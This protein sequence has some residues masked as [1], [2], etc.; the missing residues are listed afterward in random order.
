MDLFDQLQPKPS[1]MEVKHPGTGEGTGLFLDL[2][3]MSDPKVKAAERA[4]IDSLNAEAGSKPASRDDLARLKASAA[5]V[6]CEFTG[7][8]TWKGKKPEFSEALRAE[9]MANE[10]VYEQVLLHLVN[11]RNFFPV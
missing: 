4:Y 11:D 7:E 8:A 2:V 9:I 6:G 3:S 1:R 10:K 5:L